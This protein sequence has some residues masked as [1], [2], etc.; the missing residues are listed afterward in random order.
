MTIQIRIHD[1]INIKTRTYR[2]VYKNIYSQLLAGFY[3]Q[4][5]FSEWGTMV[6]LKGNDKFLIAKFGKVIV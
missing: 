5:T 2:N 3:A 6:Q 1:G 4:Q